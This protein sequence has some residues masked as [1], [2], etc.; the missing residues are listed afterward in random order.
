M[1]TK[2]EVRLNALSDRGTAVPW[3]LWGILG[4]GLIV[5]VLFIGNQ[6]FKVD[7]DT[8]EAWALSLNAHPFSQFYSA[9]SFADYPPGYFYVLWFVGH[10]FSLLGPRS[11]AYTLLGRLS[12]LPAIV[13]D[14]VDGAVLYAL[15][16]RFASARWALFASA[17]FVL[18]PAT[19]FISAVWGQ[20]DSVS[21]GFALIGVYLLL[22][23]EDRD[24]SS[25]AWEITLGWVA[26]AYSLLV[27]P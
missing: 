6:G 3:M 11:H 13:M 21:A 26:L 4:L 22:R 5:R 19:T 2:T 24:N 9:T 14:L 15:V 23:S 17:F 10:V 12:K 18:N 8:Y 27:K 1:S 7:I 16:R 20:V 25:F